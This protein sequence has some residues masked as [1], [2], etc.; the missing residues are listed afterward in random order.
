MYVH[1]SYTYIYNWC[2]CCCCCFLSF[3]DLREARGGENCFSHNNNNNDRTR[4]KKLKKK[5]EIHTHT[6]TR[7]GHIIRLD[8]RQ[9]ARF[10]SF[11]PVLVDA[12]L[13]WK[14]SS[15]APGSSYSSLLQFF[16]F[17]FFTYYFTHQSLCER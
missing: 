15:L 17:F 9:S 3:F 13:Q 1:P 7:Q 4:H 12:A 2:C 6:Q 5:R 10:F 11:V 8:A 14:N 16:F